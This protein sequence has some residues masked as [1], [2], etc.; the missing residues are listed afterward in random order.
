MEEKIGKKQ[1]TRSQIGRSSRAKGANFERKLAN[2][3]KARGFDAR[4]GVQFNGMFDHDVTTDIPFNFEAKAVES[5][6][7]YKAYKQSTSDARVDGS[8]PLVVHKKNNNPILCTMGFDDF[9]DMLQW[10]LGYVDEENTMDLKETRDKYV[11]KMQTE[12]DA[13]ELL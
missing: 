4:R 13:E 2:M 10:A 6:N 9:I 8:T 12:T 5:L 3:L 1:R 11:K 7:I